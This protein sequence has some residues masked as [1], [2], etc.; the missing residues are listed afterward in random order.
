MK[1]VWEKREQP[2]KAVSSYFR[3]NA[4]GISHFIKLSLPVRPTIFRT[5]LIA[6]F[7]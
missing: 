5:P 3:Y 4:V 2:W 1:A 6:S 7:T